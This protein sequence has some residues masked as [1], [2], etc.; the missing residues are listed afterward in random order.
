MKFETFS[1]KQSLVL[2][3]W[4]DSSPHRDFDAVIC[5]GAVRSGKTLCMGISYLC[6]AMRR[7]DG[8][9][10]GMCGKTIISLRRNV[11]SVVLPV[12]RDLG[13]VCEEKISKNY[14]TLAFGGR[15]N[16]FYLF[17]GRDESSQALIQGS[18]FAGILLDEVALMPKSFVEQALAR[19]S[20][21]GS[22]LWFNCNPEGL[23]KLSNKKY[24]TVKIQMI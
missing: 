19:C 17:G 10:F 13:F 20:V 21:T 23:T 11:V 4:S 15:K 2:T 18:T 8:Q 3:W 9:S 22:K 14:F 6:W 16:T 5:D 12:M 1:E 24:P 7:F